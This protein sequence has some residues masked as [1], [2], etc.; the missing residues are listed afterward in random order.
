MLRTSSSL[1][2][3]VHTAHMEGSEDALVL[4]YIELAQVNTVQLGKPAGV[5]VKTL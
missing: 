3:R 1:R 2:L 4:T 5:E